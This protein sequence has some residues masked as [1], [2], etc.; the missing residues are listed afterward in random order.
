MLAILTTAACLTFGIILYQ[1]FGQLGGN[2]S[3]F[4]LFR[5]F[6]IAFYLDQQI[7]SALKEGTLDM[8]G[9]LNIVARNIRF[10]TYKGF[11]EDDVRS[12]ARHMAS[13][14]GF[15]GGYVRFGQKETVFM[16][17]LMSNQ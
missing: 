7:E 12:V 13:K 14:K 6:R 2:P 5:V 9:N 15:A 8:F 10:L 3:R 4:Q 17:K 16:F 1:Y 11:L